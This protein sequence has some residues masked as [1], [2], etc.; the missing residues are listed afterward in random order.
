MTKSKTPGQVAHQARWQKSDAPSEYDWRNADLPTRQRWEE[1][2]AAVIAHHEATRERDVIDL[3]NK[4][5][6]DLVARINAAEAAQVSGFYED[7]FPQYIQGP[8]TN[9]LLSLITAEEA[10]GLVTKLAASQ[11]AVRELRGACQYVVD[12]HAFESSPHHLT[13]VAKV[14]A[15]ALAKHAPKEETE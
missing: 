8:P 13:Y 9:E 6:A 4:G 7:E 11:E 15:A 1:V 10:N 5:A 2:A 14:C 3:L 12:Q